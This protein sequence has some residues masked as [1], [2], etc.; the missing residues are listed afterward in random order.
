[1]FRDRAYYEPL[2]AEPRAAQTAVLFPAGSG[3]VPFAANPGRHLAWD[4]SLGREIP[5]LGWQSSRAG[6]DELG[7]PQKSFGV[8]LFFPLSFH[9]IEDMGKDESN[10]ILNTDYRFG[11]MVKA[12]WGLPHQWGPIQDG[13]VGLRYVFLGHESTHLGDEFTLAAT[14]IYGRAFQRV[15]VSYEYWELGGSFEPNVLADGRLRLRLRGGVI[16]VFDQQKG[17]YDSRLLQPFGD[18]IAPSRRNVEP[19]LGVDLSLHPGAN[20]FAPFGSFDFRDRTVYGYARN[21][22]ADPDDVQGS[23]NILAGVHHVRD[24]ANIQ[25]SYYVRYYYGVNPAGQFRSQK[26]YQLF[27]IGIRFHF[28]IEL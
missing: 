8:G 14:R 24:N 28:N 16:R 17:W 3:S 22:A 4:I 7:V 25:P 19:Y 5:I 11:G 23:I 10:P 6:A 21:S 26:N 18:T 27:G 15:N 20:G 2:S 13:H 1:M 9:M 12:Q